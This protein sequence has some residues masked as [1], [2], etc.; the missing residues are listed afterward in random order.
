MLK[1][2]IKVG[3]SYAAKVSGTVQVV[4]ITAEHPAKGWVGVN[5]RTGRTIRILSAARLRRQV[6][7]VDTIHVP[8][9]KSGQITTLRVVR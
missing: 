6:T 1:K 5:V 9:E 8:N 7:A 4:K 3:A 2:D